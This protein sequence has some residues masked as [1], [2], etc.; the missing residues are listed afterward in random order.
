MLLLLEIIIA[1]ETIWSNL[2]F[3]I[4]KSNDF[5]D[6]VYL[7]VWH[8]C[9]ISKWTSLTP[10]FMVYLRTCRPSSVQ[11]TLC[12]CTEMHALSLHC[13]R[14]FLKKSQNYEAFF[15]LK[16]SKIGFNVP[17]KVIYKLKIVK[18]SLRLKVWC[19]LISVF[20]F[21]RKK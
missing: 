15:S 17:I 2:G 16:I 14:N 18:T 19:I 5:V 12:K 13:G 20:R 4:K 3:N 11:C 21:I 9:I 7:I 6:T 1:R 10:N 8:R